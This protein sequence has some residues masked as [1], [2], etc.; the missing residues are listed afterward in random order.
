MAYLL[1]TDNEFGFSMTDIAGFLGV[2]QGTISNWVKEA[3]YEIAV[4]NLDKE[5]D[6]TRNYLVSLELNTHSELSGKL[7]NLEDRKSEC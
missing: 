6:E 1:H 2:S 7:D 5:L 3:K 4:K